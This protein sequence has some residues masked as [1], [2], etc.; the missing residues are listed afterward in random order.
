M[1]KNLPPKLKTLKIS[2]KNVAIKLGDFL[3]LLFLITKLEIAPSTEVLLSLS[4]LYHCNTD[5]LLRKIIHPLLF[6]LILLNYHNP[7]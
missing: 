6:L 7:R 4:Y 2:P 5:Y 1:I 3:F